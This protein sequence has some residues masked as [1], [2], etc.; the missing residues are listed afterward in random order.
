MI[1]RRKS[2]E[3]RGTEGAILDTSI[4]PGIED[5]GVWV[6]WFL[7]FQQSIRQSNWLKMRGKGG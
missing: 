4:G 5:E 2:W 1:G 3:E 7:F 6:S